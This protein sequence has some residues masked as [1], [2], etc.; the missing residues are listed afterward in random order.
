MNYYKF[1]YKCKLCQKDY[2]SDYPKDKRI[3]HVCGMKVIGK[4]VIGG[5]YDKAKL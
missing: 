4:K 3:C 5:S 1:T 2:G